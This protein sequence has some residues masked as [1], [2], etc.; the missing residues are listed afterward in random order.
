[1]KYFI[2]LSFL[3]F[4]GCKKESN[5]PRIED[6]LSINYFGNMWV[7]SVPQSKQVVYV[8][9][10]RTGKYYFATSI[11]S[12]NYQNEPELTKS[13]VKGDEVY[14]AINNPKFQVT[15]SGKGCYANFG[16][17]YEFSGEK[18]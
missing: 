5:N 10:R 9:M 14:T 16:N 13:I 15:L 8:F 3:F 6:D 12:V 2:I 18:R 11:N 1:M 17:G 4:L 7:N